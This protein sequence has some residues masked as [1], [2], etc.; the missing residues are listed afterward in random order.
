MMAD[1][2]A[3]GIVK[4]V[5]VGVG[6]A[7]ALGTTLVTVTVFVTRHGGRI[8]ALERAEKHDVKEHETLFTK[9]DDLAK[10]VGEVKVDVG[11]IKT[12][13]KYLVDRANGQDTR[14]IER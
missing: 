7:L 3:A 10:D 13:I 9:V 8:R 4:L 1:W 11:V 5:F 6:V 12:H 2:D 14:R